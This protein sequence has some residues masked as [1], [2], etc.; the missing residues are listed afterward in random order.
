[1]R[2]TRQAQ[3]TQTNKVSAPTDGRTLRRSRNR[4]AV[5]AALLDL[6]REGNLEPGAAEIADRAGVSH[7]SVFR[8]FDDLSDLVRI[9][10]GREFNAAEATAQVPEV[11]EGTFEDRVTRFVDSRIVLHERIRGVALVARMR[12][13]S[14]PAFD[15]E[16]ATADLYLREQAREHFAEELSAWNLTEREFILDACTVL[17]GFGSF[18]IHQR[19]MSHSIERIKISWTKSLGALLKS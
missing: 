2:A 14:I 4:D 10:V 16:L 6:I 5:I 7:R 17:T 15:Q 13:N 12:A 1:M 3:A 18:D 8:Y 9:A 19:R 11:G